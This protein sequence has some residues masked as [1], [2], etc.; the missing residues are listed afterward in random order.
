MVFSEYDL[1]G[2]WFVG[3]CLLCSRSEI[4]KRLD[5]MESAVA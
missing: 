3:I 2:D 1:D 5:L 4:W